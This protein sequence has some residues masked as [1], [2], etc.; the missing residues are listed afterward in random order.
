MLFTSSLSP[1]LSLNLNFKALINAKNEHLSHREVTG[2]LI[3][4]LAR[5]TLPLNTANDVWP[6]LN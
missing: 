1:V 6:I 5:D 4:R 2:A 3:G